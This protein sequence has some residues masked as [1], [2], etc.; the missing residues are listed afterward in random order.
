MRCS[1]RCSLR[2][3]RR[4]SLRASDF[5]VGFSGSIR[6]LALTGISIL[7][8]RPPD[9]VYPP[10]SVCNPPAGHAHP[11]SSRAQRGTC[12]FSYVCR[13]E[14]I[15]PT[16]ALRR[17]SSS[18]GRSRLEPTSNLQNCYR[19]VSSLFTKIFQSTKVITAVKNEG[20]HYLPSYLSGG[21]E[22]SRRGGHRT[23]EGMPPSAERNRGSYG[24]NHPTDG[25]SPSALRREN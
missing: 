19:V 7:L 2:G 3:S 5:S 15:F 25:F 23:R 13:G 22:I 14:F 17:R 12:C 6:S 1:M 8:S 24:P 16:L 10:P 20:F 4:S 11:L 21:I 18:I 9:N